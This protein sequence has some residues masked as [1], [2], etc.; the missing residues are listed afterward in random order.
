MCE[1]SRDRFIAHHKLLFLRFCLPGEI[2]GC[3][4]IFIVHRKKCALREI[5]DRA[6][7]PALGGILAKHKPKSSVYYFK[8]CSNPICVKN[9]RFFRKM[10]INIPTFSNV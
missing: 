4:I 9:Q 10:R 2:M 3:G 6:A 8:N 1:K 5:V 7:F